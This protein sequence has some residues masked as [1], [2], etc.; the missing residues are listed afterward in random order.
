MAKSAFGLK[1]MRMNAVGG[2]LVARFI[3]KAIARSIFFHIKAKLNVLQL[4]KITSFGI[5]AYPYCISNASTLSV[6]FIESNSF[7]LNSLIDLR[8]GVMTF[9]TP[10]AI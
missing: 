5:K 9:S 4:L 8:T 6:V 1:T 3:E 2:V 7:E 10:S